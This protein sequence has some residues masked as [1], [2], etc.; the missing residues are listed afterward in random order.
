M[1]PPRR[2]RIE[3]CGDAIL[4]ARSRSLVLILLADGHDVVRLGLRHLLEREQG[5]EVCGEARDGREVVALAE[6]LK[7]DVAV[8]DITMSGLN[9]VEATRKIRAASPDSEVLVFTM[10]GSEEVMREVFAA[11]ARGYLMKSDA[12]RYIV[13]A[14][15]ALAKHQPFFSSQVAATLLGAFLREGATK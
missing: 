6:Q 7:P 8:L 11:G 13:A 9:G 2:R 5:W 10:D 4:W 3:A 15:E 1:I 12:A 14:V